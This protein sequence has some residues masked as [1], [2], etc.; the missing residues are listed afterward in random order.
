MTKPSF[1][2]KLIGFT[3]ISWMLTVIK[4]IA[5]GVEKLNI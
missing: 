4:S 2:L 3:W 1:S 5:Q